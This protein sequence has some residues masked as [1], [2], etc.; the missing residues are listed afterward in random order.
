LALP[1]LRGESRFQSQVQPPRAELARLDAVIPAEHTLAAL[2]VELAVGERGRVR[3]VIVVP[4]LG[5]SRQDQILTARGARALVEPQREADD[6]PILDNL[7][8]LKAHHRRSPR[9]PNAQAHRPRRLGK[10]EPWNHLMPPRS[11][12]AFGSALPDSSLVITVRVRVL[13]PG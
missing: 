5:V 6:G 8:R 11:G 9:W 13:E 10:L 3:R 7:A 12:A 1:D 2:Q 4:G